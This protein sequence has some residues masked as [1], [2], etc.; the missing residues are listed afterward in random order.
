MQFAQ[1][2]DYFWTKSRSC[3]P[4]IK[5]WTDS[6]IIQAPW[7]QSHTRRSKSRLLLRS[8]TWFL[9]SRWGKSTDA[10]VCIEQQRGTEGCGVQR[11][12]NVLLPAEDER[13]RKRAADQRP[14]KEKGSFAVTLLWEGSATANKAATQREF[15]T[16]WQNNK[17]QGHCQQVPVLFVEQNNMEKFETNLNV[18]WLQSG[19]HQRWLVRLPSDLLPPHFSVCFLTTSEMSSSSLGT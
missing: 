2:K 19:S 1:K 16:R 14:L 5:E 11:N 6:C 7:W 4:W 12:N 9:T 10:A 8:Q 3:Y 15:I 17:G 18:C 13:G